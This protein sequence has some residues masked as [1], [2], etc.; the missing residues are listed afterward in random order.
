[1][2]RLV[3]VLMGVMFF[4]GIS[5][6]QNIGPGVPAKNLQGNIATPNLGVGYNFHQAEYDGVD[7][8]QHQVYAH[9]GAVFGDA[10]T[11]SYE[12]YMRFGAATLEDDDDFDGGTEPMY[13]AGIKGE[14]YQGKVF[15]W[16]GVLQGLYIDKYEDS[17][18][19]N[20]QKVD[21]SLEENWEVEL[22][23]PF[24]A[25]IK[26]G[27]VYLGPVFYSATTDVVSNNISQDEGD[28]D[29]DNNVGAFGG[30][31]FRSANVSFEIEAKYRSDLSAGAL[32]TFAF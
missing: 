31:V 9:I 18:Q 17:I 23:F 20:N 12:V 28:L 22:A 29:E 7:I 14:F 21:I 2:K 13:A 16:G 30:I 1:M 8:E 6:A 26:N 27:L 32:V 10:S 3:L 19:V 4:S 11:P 15:G 5:Y 25:Y 24:H